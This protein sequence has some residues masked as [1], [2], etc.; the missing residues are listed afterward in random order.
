MAVAMAVA[1]ATA[2]ATA[3][4]LAMDMDMA[5]APAGRSRAAKSRRLTLRIGAVAAAL[6]GITW[7]LIIGAIP[8]TDFLERASQ[9]ARHEAPAPTLQGW[10]GEL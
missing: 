9:G 1:M 6:A 10:L 7:R 2:L 5:T 8:V 4:A 3:M